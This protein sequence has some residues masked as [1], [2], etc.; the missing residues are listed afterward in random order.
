MADPSPSAV[1]QQVALGVPALL[2]QDAEYFLASIVSDLAPL[3]VLIC[4]VYDG[5]VLK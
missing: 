3:G 1:L 5:T 2:L 4:S